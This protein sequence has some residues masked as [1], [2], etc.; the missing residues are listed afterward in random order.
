MNKLI[1]LAMGLAALC[2]AC[3]ESTTEPTENGETTGGLDGEYE[4][5]FTVTSTLD[6]NDCVLPAPL[7]VGVNITIDDDSI[8][9]A[10]FG[11][12]WDTDTKTGSGVTP[13]TTIPVTPPTCNAYYWVTFD[14]T[15]T[16]KD[17]FSGTYRVDYRKDAE[18]TNPDPCYY[19]YSISGAR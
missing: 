12:S 17:H 1:I 16:D 14:I 7:P 2:G 9:F 13:E 15:Y 11:G 5:T 3:S 18:C 10:E 8:T 4:G 6:Y 19:T